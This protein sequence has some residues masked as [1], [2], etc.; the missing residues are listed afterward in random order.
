VRGQ[1]GGPASDASLRSAAHCLPCHLL[2]SAPSTAARCGLL[3]ACGSPLTSLQLAT[4]RSTWFA[5]SR[6]AARGL[7]AVP[8]L[9][10]PLSPSSLARVPGRY[11]PT[12]ATR[13]RRTS[14]SGSTLSCASSPC[15]SPGSPCGYPSAP[16][17]ACKRITQLTGHAA[18]RIW[19][20][21]R[22]LGG[23]FGAGCVGEGGL[24][25]DRPTLRRQGYYEMSDTA[26]QAPPSSDRPSTAESTT[27]LPSMLESQS[28][29]PVVPTSTERMTSTHSKVCAR[30]ARACASA[31]C[32]HA[33]SASRGLARVL[34]LGL[35]ATDRGASDPGRC[36]RVRVAAVAAAAAARALPSLSLCLTAALPRAARLFP[37]AEAP[38]PPCSRPRSRC[39]PRT[40]TTSRP[41]YR[42]ARPSAPTSATESRAL[43]C[44]T[45]CVT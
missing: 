4:G 11:R 2:F 22:L 24:D 35:C 6:C 16:A 45:Q 43:H 9:A 39:C 40:T 19:A 33:A 14:C 10:Y 38:R 18:L 26:S 44:T 1:R 27:E 36:Q 5:V 31:E 20:A 7:C 29:A 15:A 8:S 3:W 17:P 37:W 23:A 21:D 34:V 30:A 12:P 13:G 42:G 28:A 25:N 32:V 41:R